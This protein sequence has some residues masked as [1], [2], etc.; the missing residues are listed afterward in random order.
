MMK[1]VIVTALD[2]MVQMVKKDESAWEMK[3]S[4]GNSP[5]GR[6]VS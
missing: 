3:E 4:I 5:R 6:S 1:L 2:E